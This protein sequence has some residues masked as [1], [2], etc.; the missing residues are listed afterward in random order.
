MPVSSWQPLA[1]KH[2]AFFS[3]DW[4]L[5]S[6]PGKIVLLA[7]KEPKTVEL[8]LNK[9]FKR[10]THHLQIKPVH[11]KGN[12]RWIFIGR[13]DADAEAPVLWL[14]DVGKD[15][16]QEEKGTIEDE[17]AGWHHRVELSQLQELVMDRE[18]WHTPTHGIAKSQIR[19]S[20]WITTHH[21]ISYLFGSGTL[22]L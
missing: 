13:T 21:L 5:C 16:R 6:N 22:W 2:T 18:A 14:P 17:M 20:H 3:N 9:N 4:F 10:L 15:W 8:R 12:Q 19:L 7:P 11:P 1:V